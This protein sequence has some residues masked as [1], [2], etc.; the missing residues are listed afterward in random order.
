MCAAKAKST[1]MMLRPVR[2]IIF[3][4]SLQRGAANPRV[5]ELSDTTSSVRCA[6]EPGVPAKGV[7]QVSKTRQ[8]LVYSACSCEWLILTAAVRA[9]RVFAC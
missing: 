3:L 4:A 2:R 6:A 7:G 5:N 1:L 9:A 8:A